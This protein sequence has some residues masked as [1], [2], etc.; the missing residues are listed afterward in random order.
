M[1]AFDGLDELPATPTMLL[2]D[3]EEDT[4]DKELEDGLWVIGLVGAVAA[5]VDATGESQGFKK[6]MSP[7]LSPASARCWERLETS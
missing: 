5:D 2:I 3:D 7:C 6:I 4:V 1:F